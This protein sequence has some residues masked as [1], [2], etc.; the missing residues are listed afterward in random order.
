MLKLGRGFTLVELIVAIAIVAILMTL[1]APNL[2]LWIRNTKVRTAAE[3]IQ[4]GL[5]VARAEALKR[6]AVVR[7]QLTDT[8]DDSCSL[9]DNGP[10]WFISISD[11]T[12]GTSGSNDHKC[13]TPASDTE[14]PRIIQSRNGA[15]AGG[16]LV[17]INSD[18]NLLT[19]NGLGQLTSNPATM[20]I[21]SAEAGQT[22]MADGGSTR[23]LSVVVTAGGQIRMCDPALPSTDTRG[24]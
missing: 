6:N 20:Q 1:A 7:F 13:A 14:G 2:S 16:N 8:M 24:C 11:V 9:S 22:C 12:A 23:C 5:H 18:R 3:S 10:H 4:T 17:F 19:F 21:S 15:E